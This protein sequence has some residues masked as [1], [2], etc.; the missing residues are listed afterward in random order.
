M[1]NLRK[2]TV[3]V[4]ALL[5]VFAFSATAFAGSITI[6]RDTTYGEGSGDGRA[7]SYYKVFSADKTLADQDFEGGHVDGVPNA[8]QGDEKVAYTATSTV[9]AKLGTWNAETKAWTKADGNLWFDLAPIAGST[10]YS[11]K[12]VGADNTAATI[13]AAA[14]WLIE[15]EAYEDGPVEMP[16]AEGKWT[17]ANIDDG[18]YIISSDTGKNL[19]AVTNDIEI[20]EKNDYPST[21]KTQADEDSE[22]QSDTEASVAIGDILSYEAKVTIPAAAKVGDTIVV[23]DTPSAG[24]TYNNDVQVKT[25]EGNATVT[26]GTAGEG[27]A[28]TATITVTEESIGKDVVFEYTMTVN[29]DALV[30]TG[31]VNTIDLKYG[32]NYEAKP[33]SVTYTTYFAGI[34]KIDGDTKDAEDGPTSLAGV[35]FELKEDGV[36]F[37]VTKTDAG[38]YIPGGTSNEVV[39][40]EA[41]LIKI[42]GLDN[43][44]TYTLTETATLDGYNML[45][46]DVTLTLKEDK[47]TAFADTTT[48]GWDLVENNQGTVLPSTGGVGTTIFYIL[49]V[50]LVAG[51]GVVLVSRKRMSNK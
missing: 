36:A 31:R 35:K 4:L 11:V 10:D 6:T 23:T 17:A 37:N 41:G 34:H 26:F 8:A 44:K 19:V 48:D 39:T 40:D 27:Q 49:G 2:V 15:N 24:L 20:K 5:V 45:A 29:A 50:V 22:T 32:D 12:W 28:W 13:Q 38:Y 46:S 43:D 25:N 18:Y 9:A 21:D 1:K 16:F 33:D 30:D 42:R 51:C 3:L 7:Y 14:A 47:G